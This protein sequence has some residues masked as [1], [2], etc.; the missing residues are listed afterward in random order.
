M[1]SRGPSTGALRPNVLITGTPGEPPAEG[2]PH[3]VNIVTFNGRGFL[4]CVGFIGAVPA[5]GTGKSLTAEEV[6]SRTGM[7]HVDVGQLAKQ[8]NLFDGWD[9][10]YQCP[11]LDE[12]KVTTPPRDDKPLKTEGYPACLTPFTLVRCVRLFNS[13]LC[14]T[15]N[16]R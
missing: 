7:R 12:D 2:P 11:V 9:E 16:H 8:Q 10:Q 4:W 15:S 3:A 14:E 13:I 6:C 5:T 1:A